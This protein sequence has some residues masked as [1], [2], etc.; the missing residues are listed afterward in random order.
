MWRE[1][2]NPSL[3]TSNILA[4]SRNGQDGFS[5]LQLLNSA[6][7]YEFAKTFKVVTRFWF[8]F[9]YVALYGSAKLQSNQVMIARFYVDTNILKLLFIFL[10]CC[11]SSYQC[12]LEKSYF[13]SIK[14][15][16]KQMNCRILLSQKAK[17]SSDRFWTYVSHT[18]ISY[19]CF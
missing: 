10:S 9:V 6:V 1:G 5:I 17:T 8:R 16:W 15:I 18:Y 11:G 13:D 14:C 19:I 12:G 7:D 3:V 2:S 4:R